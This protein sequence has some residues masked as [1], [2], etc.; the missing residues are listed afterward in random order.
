[1]DVTVPWISTDEENVAQSYKAL[2][3]EMGSEPKIPNSEVH[4]SFHHNT[5]HACKKN[6]H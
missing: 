6:L 3:T 2:D 5:C 1:M 4:C